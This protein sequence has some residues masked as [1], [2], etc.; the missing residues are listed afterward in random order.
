M[1]GYSNVVDSQG[2]Y[3]TNY[4]VKAQ[5]LKLIKNIAFQSYN[6]GM[7][8][9]NAA[10]LIWNVLR[11]NMWGIIRENEGGSLVMK[12]LENNQ[13]FPATFSHI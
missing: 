11:T 12:E 3:P 9:G 8:R 2:T 13:I 10:I 4:I 1:L 6:E 5:D 7:T